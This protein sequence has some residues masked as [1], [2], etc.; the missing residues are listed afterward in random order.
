MSQ[1]MGRDS[2]EDKQPSL[3][4][5]EAKEIFE[6]GVMGTVEFRNWLARAFPDFA[7]IRDNDV[8]RDIQNIAELRQKRIEA[9]ATLGGN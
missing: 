4:F 2:S 7:A 6:K 3:T 8:D 9:E 5:E 1:P